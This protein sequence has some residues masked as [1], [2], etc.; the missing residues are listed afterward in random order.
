MKSNDSSI[1]DV[2]IIIINYNTSALVNDCLKSIFEQSSDFSYEII[3]VDNATEN[4]SE[5]IYWTDPRIRFLQLDKNL[6]FGGANNRAFEI[7][8]GRYLF[9]LNP[10]TVLINNAINILKDFL[11]IHPE[12]GACGGNLYDEAGKPALSYK[13]R[14]PGFFEDTDQLLK[15][16]LSRLFYGKNYMFN[17]GI[18]PQKT[19]YINGADLMLRRTVIN[20]VGG[21][22]N[23]FFL[24]YEE[25]E[26][27]FRIRRYGYTICSVPQAKIIHLE[28]KS[29]SISRHRETL[30]LLSRK[31]YF[32]KTHGKIYKRL[33]S[34]Y[35]FVLTKLSLIIATAINNKP[36][37]SKL[38]QRVE[39]LKEI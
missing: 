20:Q 5:M 36:Y 6:G 16:G 34:S 26:L 2:S 33:I 38:K 1:I 35:Y 31:L 15:R 28:G 24:Y 10:D 18:K 4:L 14:G 12:C 8:S 39:V 29:F 27:Q 32:D 17:H 9:C 7:A 23:D 19:A 25:T 22:D 21:F 3:I 11:D 37:I 30:S 13:M